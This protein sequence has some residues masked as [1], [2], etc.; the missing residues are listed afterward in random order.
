MD[1]LEGPGEDARWLRPPLR[2]VVRVLTTNVDPGR[3]LIGALLVRMG[4]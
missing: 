2:V 4:A 3:V 1:L